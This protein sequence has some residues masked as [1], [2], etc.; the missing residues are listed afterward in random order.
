MTAIV[1]ENSGAPVLWSGSSV[2][3][4]RST[5]WPMPFPLVAWGPFIKCLIGTA[6]TP[7]RGVSRP[8]PV[9]SGT[10]PGLVPSRPGHGFASG[11][12]ARRYCVSV[13]ARSPAATSA[14]RTRWNAFFLA[15]GV[16]PVCAE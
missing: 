15:S 12:R 5:G 4:T 14:S 3:K 8:V 11:K 10:C 9:H 2:L 1:D 7:F 16:S 13:T 6:G